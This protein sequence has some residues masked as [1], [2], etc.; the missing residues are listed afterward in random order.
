MLE[1]FFLRA[2]GSVYGKGLCELEMGRDQ[3]DSRD[4]REGRDGRIAQSSALFRLL[5]ASSGFFRLLSPSSGV[6][7]VR[8]FFQWMA[9]RKVGVAIRSVKMAHV[10]AGCSLWLGLFG[11]SSVYGEGFFKGGRILTKRAERKTS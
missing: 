5:P 10:G 2:S 7:P 3:K 9:R 11:F 6:P 4:E 8:E 1:I